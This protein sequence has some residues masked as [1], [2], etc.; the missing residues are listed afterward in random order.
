[1]KKKS[2]MDVSKKDIEDI[3]KEMMR[4][5]DPIEYDYS[6]WSQADDVMVELMTLMFDYMELFGKYYYVT[7]GLNWV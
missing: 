7:T 5:Y 2:K 3:K 1:M 4:V 6:Y